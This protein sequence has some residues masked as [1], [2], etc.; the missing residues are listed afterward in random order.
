[1]T[2]YETRAASEDEADRR[3]L[4]YRFTSSTRFALTEDDV[5]YDI[6]SGRNRYAPRGKQETPEY[7]EPF[8]VQADWEEKL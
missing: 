4:L 5:L 2:T 7:M 6:R 1:M 8:D 3:A